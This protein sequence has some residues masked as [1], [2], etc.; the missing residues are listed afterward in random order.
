MDN[1]SKDTISKDN[2]NK[3][4][5]SKDNVINTDS[6]EDSKKDVVDLSDGGKSSPEA[7][8]EDESAVKIHVEVLQ[9]DDSSSEESKSDSI[10]TNNLL[11]SCAEADDDEHNVS[12]G[13]QANTTLTFTENFE[14]RKIVPPSLL[15]H[16][17]SMTEPSK[18]QTIDGELPRHCAF[19]LPGVALALGRNNWH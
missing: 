15:E 13:Q 4:N 3:D 19:T 10:W 2:V 5:I 18:A 11:S 14:N 9:S 6:N 7:T 17:V 8:A 12:S 1:D 16:Y